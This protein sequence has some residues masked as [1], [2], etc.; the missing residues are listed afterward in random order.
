M[1][2]PSHA[3][4]AGHPEHSLAIHSGRIPLAEERILRTSLAPLDKAI[5]GFEPSKT[6]LLDSDVRYV[7]E[8][9]H[10]LCVRALA[11]FEEEV[12]WID[13]GNAIDPYIL[14]ALCKR[15]GLDRHEVLSMVN[16]ARAFTAYQLASLVDGLLH[17]KV[18]ESA[19]SLIIISSISDMFM[20]RDLRRS[21]SHQLLR[22]CANEVERVT[23]ESEA[24]TV[25]T[26]HTPGRVEPEPRVISLLSDAFDVYVQMRRGRNGI[27]V[28]VPDEGRSTTFMPVPWNQMVLNDFTEGFYGKDC[29]YIPPRP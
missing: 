24:I 15:H 6:L 5:G 28:R 10:I 7:S 22:G 25:V 2:V 12:V 23:K 3:Q 29:A 4:S 20:D 8:L 9:L 21:E 11:E 14:S 19:P 18:G 17:E 27:T 1:T 26:S 16:I 13:G